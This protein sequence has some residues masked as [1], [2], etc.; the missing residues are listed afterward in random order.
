[1]ISLMTAMI[2]VIAPFSIAIPISPVPAS[3]ANLIIGIT[4]YVLGMK[5]CLISTLL[6]L[7]IGMIG[8]P[9]FSGFMG[10]VGKVFGPT[11]GYL[12]GY[13]VFVIIG[14]IFVE[15]YRERTM[16]QFFGL[17]IGMCGC[18]LLGTIWLMYQSKM[19]FVGAL[20]VGV[21]PFLL[22]DMIKLFFVVLLGKQLRLRLLTAGLLE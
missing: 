15:R 5:K 18:Y 10:G 20:T 16:I 19:T 12:V 17:G 8:M 7:L 2:C 6:Y 22:T 14:G 11:G 9:V 4:I 21:V 13:M 3:M 1:M